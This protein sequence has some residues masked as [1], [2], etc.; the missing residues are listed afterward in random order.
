M[1][2]GGSNIN[3]AAGSSSET[4]FLVTFQNQINLIHI[5]DNKANLIISI[6]S[7]I[8]SII[9]S[10][11]G[12]GAFSNNLELDKKYILI[13][14]TIIILTSL[15]SAVFAIQ[16]AK[17][18]IKRAPNKSKSNSGN[19]TSL[20]FFASTS[21]KTLEEYMTAMDKVLESRTSIKDQMVIDIFNQGRVLRV[22]YALLNI[23]YQIFMFGFIFGVVTF[24]IMLLV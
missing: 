7:I 1:E 8:I 18:V 17:P 22:K 13:P 14:V 19:R 4:M 15:I 16:A 12:L 5:A 24:L 11:A 9:I 2:N 21:R 23:A 10:A 6:N 20:L 3:E